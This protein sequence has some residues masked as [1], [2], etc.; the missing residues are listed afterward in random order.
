MNTD[1]YI[2]QLEETIDR[3]T[4]HNKMLIEETEIANKQVEVLQQT[5]LK[6]RN[7][8]L[9]EKWAG[10]PMVDRNPRIPPPPNLYIPLSPKGF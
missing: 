7:D 4:T 8:K 10:E 5:V 1:L 3:L 9:L 6:M 2:K